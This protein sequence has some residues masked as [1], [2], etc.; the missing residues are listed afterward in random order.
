MSAADHAFFASLIAA[1][2]SSLV[3]ASSCASSFAWFF[4]FSSCLA[5]IWSQ[6]LLSSRAASRAAFASRCLDILTARIT[7][8]TLE[9]V[10]GM[11]PPVVRVYY[12]DDFLQLSRTQS[13]RPY[14][15]R[16]A[17]RV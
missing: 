6:E 4:W 12:T 9:K 14:V 17:T 10:N 11:I 5:W 16:V 3:R 7:A 13:A 15:L 1:R 2:N 8:L